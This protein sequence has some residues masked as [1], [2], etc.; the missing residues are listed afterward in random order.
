MLKRV[1]CYKSIKEAYPRPK[2]RLKI[3]IGVRTTDIYVIRPHQ[4]KRLVL[5][6]L[7]KYRK[8]Y[9]PEGEM[10]KMTPEGERRLGNIID[11][12]SKN[13]ES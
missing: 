6:P 9:K 5:I 4:R 10:G 13:E 11:R 3:N 1:K 12:G 8:Q 7:T 2:S